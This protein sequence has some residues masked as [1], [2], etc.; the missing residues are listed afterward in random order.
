MKTQGDAASVQPRFRVLRGKDIAMGPGKA[1]LLEELHNTGS[2]VEASEK[3]GMSYM[4][5]WTL[6]KTIER[7]FAEPLVKVSRGGAKHGGAK[8]T[9]NGTKVLKLYREMERESLLATSRVRN[10]LLKLLR[11]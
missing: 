9:V 10:Q 8:L 7:S 4:R 3:L 5:A 1:N 6:L 11:D 2:I